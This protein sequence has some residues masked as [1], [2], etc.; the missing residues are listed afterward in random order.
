VL[1][2]QVVIV[3]AGQVGTSIADSLSSDHDVVVVD[4]D[5]DIVDDI[6]YELDVL[7]LAGDGTSS[8]LL[9]DA[10]VPDADLVIASTDDDKTNLVT[11]GTAKTVGE[12]FT[13]ARVKSAEYRRTWVRTEEAF[14]VDFMVCTDL[15]TAENVVNI[16][17]LPSAINVDTFANGLVEMA[18]FDITENSP[19][20]GQTVADADRFDSLTFAALYRDDDIV[21]PQGDT[22]VRSD[23]RAV[24]IGSPQ[25]IQEFAQRIAPSKTP[26]EAE[27][28]VIVGGSKIGYHTARLLE[29]RDFSPKLIE[30]DPDRARELA[31]QL[32][33]TIVMQQD[34]TDTDFL[35]RENVDDADILVSALESDE[36]NMLVSLLAKRIGTERVISLVEQTDYVELFEE[37]GVDV[38]IN[39]R[40]VTAEQITRF[41]Y[42]EV[43]LNVSVIENDQAEVLELEVSPDSELVGQAIENIDDSLETNLVFGAVTRGREHIIPRGET[44][45]QAGDHIIVFVETSFVDDLTAMT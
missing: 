24:V 12:P 42:Q 22:V 15:E 43:A 34:A 1:P 32:P 35:E 23:D 40:T 19:I 14:G 13:I 8:D 9:E 39:P 37:I 33:G 5:E 41:T 2:M 4:I 28:I 36:R 20:A 26:D 25:S 38:A 45:L 27:D 16:I 30:Q 18:V 29:R 11:C 21:L 6:K 44:V 3:G 10:E 17:G 31:E 7:T